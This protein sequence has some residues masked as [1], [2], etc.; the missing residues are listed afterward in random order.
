MKNKGFIFLLLGIFVVVIAA[1]LGIHFLTQPKEEGDKDNKDK[2]QKV[3]TYEVTDQKILDVLTIMDGPGCDTVVETF[4]NDHTVYAKDISSSIA[5]A[6]PWHRGDLEGKSKVS[7]EEYSKLVQKYYGKDYKLE[8]KK[9]DALLC[10]WYYDENENAY[11]KNPEPACGCTGDPA[12]TRY[13]VVKAVQTGDELV[14]EL[15]VAFYR[16]SGDCFYEDFEGTRSI[17]TTEMRVDGMDFIDSDAAYSKASLYK[18]TFKEVDGNYV[19]VS[20]ERA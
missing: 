9:G 4:C 14:I 13:R 7:V 6:L 2:D 16:N 17:P 11:M 5:I 12:Y 20:S 1:I 15:R 18:M 8:P 3:V 10:V 19:F